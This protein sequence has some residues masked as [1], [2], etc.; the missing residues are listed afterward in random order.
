MSRIIGEIH[1][2]YK[3]IKKEFRFAEAIA[4]TQTAIEIRKDVL[5]K[6][7]R[8]VF[9]RPTRFVQNAFYYKKATKKNL[10]ALV[11]IK[12]PGTFAGTAGIKGKGGKQLTSSGV[13]LTAILGPHIE[14]GKRQPKAS[15]KRLR[16]EGI[17]RS[18]E[19]LVPAKGV[20]LDKYGN[21]RGPFMVKILSALSSFN[22]AGFD[23]NVTDVSRERHRKA[24]K[25]IPKVFVIKSGSKSH[26]KPG[27][28]Q[29]FGS[30]KNP[31]VKP[32]FIFVKSPIY[33]RRFKFFETIDMGFNKIFPK[34][35]DEAII[36]YVKG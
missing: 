3:D 10:K 11:G 9:D 16:R 25:P 28:Y 20:R 19:F 24:S 32:L 7:V 27:I 29:R 17:L 8:R 18:D 2:A 4:L 26:L 22:E 1:R 35:I 36:K 14:G 31:R 34:R 6:E 23:A 12:E 13:D 30:K 21:V 5:P 33:K 15:E